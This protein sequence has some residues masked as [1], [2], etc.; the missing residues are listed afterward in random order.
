MNLARDH[1]VT[2]EIGVDFTFQHFIP[3]W[4]FGLY[5]TR[6]SAGSKFCR[7]PGALKGLGDGKPRE[8]LIFRSVQ[9]DRLKITCA[10][11]WIRHL[12]ASHESN[13]PLS[14]QP[15]HPRKKLPTHFYLFIMFIFLKCPSGMC[16]CVCVLGA[17]F[18]LKVLLVFKCIFLGT[19]VRI[20]PAGGFMFWSLIVSE[21][22]PVVHTE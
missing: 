5:L 3:C 11:N 10:V 21:M 13:V 20:S 12:W 19:I 15:R 18:F 4:N 2:Q 9:Q 22:A 7:L 1:L 6:W 17:A 8:I 16:V 14:C